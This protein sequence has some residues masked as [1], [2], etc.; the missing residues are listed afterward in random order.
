M[1]TVQKQLINYLEKKIDKDSLFCYKR[2]HKKFIENKKI[3]SKTQQKF[4]RKRQN[5]FAAEINQIALNL[6]DDKRMQ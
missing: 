3:I 2:K 6:N 5:V 4:K 1:K